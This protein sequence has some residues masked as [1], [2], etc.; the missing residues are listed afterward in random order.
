MAQSGLIW[1]FQDAGGGGGG[2][3][4]GYVNPFYTPWI[5]GLALKENEWQ[6]TPMQ[7]SMIACGC[8][9]F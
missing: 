3:P 1:L 9:I 8:G 6:I 2:H 4:Y 7:A 5:Y